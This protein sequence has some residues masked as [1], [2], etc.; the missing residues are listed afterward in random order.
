MNLF[1]IGKDIKHQNTIR[2]LVYPNITFQEDLEKDS[3]I[4]VIKNQIKLLNSIRDD[5]WFYLV[6]T[7]PMA[8]LTFDNVTQFYIDLPTYPPT[9][10]S[11][12]DVGGM[13]NI[14]SQDL[15]FDLV[16]SHLPE[17]T[18]ALKNTMYN[19]T[20]HTPKFFGYCHW[21]DVKPVV[22]WTKDS[23]LQNVTG[24]LEYERCYLNTQYQKD[25]V[26]EQ[27]K[28]TFNDNVIQKLNEILT[29]HHLG[30]DEDD[31]CRLDD[32]TKDREKII[33][34][35]HRPDTYKHFDG[36][37]KI[38]DELWKI[39]QDFKV[40]IPLLG[41]P[42]R[43]YVITDKFDKQGY[44]N[45][46]KKCWVGFSPKQKYGGWSVAAT[47][48]MMNGVPYIMYDDTY[49]K[50]LWETGDFFK[51]DHGAIGL[52]NAYLDDRKY[53]DEMGLSAVTH[54]VDHLVY[55]DEMTN[56][57]GYINILIDNTK[58]MKNTEKLKELISFIK[59]NKSV[60]KKEVMGFLGW[61]RG[62]KFTPYRR[63][64]MNHPNI[65]D[66]N[67]TTPHYIWKELDND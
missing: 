40:W 51:S 61:G 17:H 10:R 36:F 33:V 55:K 2:I 25:M 34:F 56:M 44:Y 16:M 50:E 47:D 54:I 67:N 57:S 41:K 42:N 39:R 4:Q 15:D 28:D 60:T 62:I 30:V 20:H 9:M 23:F 26:L 21:F 11:H 38:M 64:L 35:N 46:L 66:I 43:D 5:L 6:L 58:Q 12:F 24:L 59:E 53:R 14:L 45:F 3:Y 52:L 19:V 29:V 37:I 18:H 27:A 63:A 48:G 31:I 13:K 7:K 8:S 65:Y 32:I 22:A 49:Y 1:E